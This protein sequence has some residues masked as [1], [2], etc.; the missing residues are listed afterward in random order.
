ML[1][2]DHD[3]HALVLGIGPGILFHDHE[4]AGLV[5]DYPLADVR[6]VARD[7]VGD[8]PLGQVARRL[9]IRGVAL[10]LEGGYD[11][12]ALRA[13]ASMTVTSLARGLIG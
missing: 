5:G 3:H 6:R 8:L 9:G 11:L 13:S 4:Q 10:T 2:L 1:G 7:D 12:E